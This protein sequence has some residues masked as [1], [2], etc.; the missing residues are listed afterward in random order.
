MTGEGQ[1]LIWKKLLRYIK[2]YRLHLLLSLVFAALSSVLA[3]YVPILTGRAIDCIVTKGQVDFDGVRHILS[4]LVA[5]A[6]VTAAAQW[7]MNICNNKI[8][9]QVVRDLRADAFAKIEILPLKYLDAHSNGELVSRVIADADQVAD[10]LLMGFTQLFAGVIT[11]LGTLCFMVS[12]QYKIA[13]VVIC[14]TP[15]SL[16]VA[17]FIAKRTFAMFKL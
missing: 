10:G 14:I 2:K 11:I 17:S 12:I 5:V 7:M 6:A 15:V 8:T 3:L 13:L 9:Y 4:Q 16:F 1:S